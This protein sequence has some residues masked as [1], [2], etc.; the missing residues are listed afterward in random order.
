MGIGD[1]EGTDN[2]GFWAQ[3]SDSVIYACYILV[4]ATSVKCFWDISIPK[5]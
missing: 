1:Y 4:I 2:V 5:D 3:M